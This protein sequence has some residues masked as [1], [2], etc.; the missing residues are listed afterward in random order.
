LRLIVDISKILKPLILEIKLEL[1]LPPVIIFYRD[2]SL[3][4]NCRFAKTCPAVGE[5]SQS[6]YTNDPAQAHPAGGEFT[7]SNGSIA[8]GWYWEIDR[9]WYKRALDVGAGK[10]TWNIPIEYKDDNGVFQKTGIISAQTG[11]FDGKGGC[12]ATKCGISVTRVP[13][14]QSLYDQAPQNYTGGFEYK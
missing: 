12:T 10:Y 3:L 5:G 14:N 11:V 6:I 9:V 2:T 7:P 1:N 8:N 4:Q 13:K